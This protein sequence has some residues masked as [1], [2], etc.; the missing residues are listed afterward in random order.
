MSAATAHVP[1]QLRVHNVCVVRYRRRLD[2]DRI[3]E[4]AWYLNET[5]AGDV[6]VL[7]LLLGPTRNERQRVR[8][9]ALQKPADRSPTWHLSNE[10]VVD[11]DALEGPDNGPAAEVR[12]RSLAAFVALWGN[13]GDLAGASFLRG[14]R[15]RCGLDG[16]DE[17]RVSRLARFLRRNPQRAL[18]IFHSAFRGF[19]VVDTEK[20]LTEVWLP[21]DHGNFHR[22][23][24]R[25]AAYIL[26]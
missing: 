23:E 16:H 1:R 3:A 18:A 12:D 15:L 22:V 8:A 17:I 2:V 19:V 21:R 14:Q 10:P 24:G 20:M 9:W 13:S 26:Y 7:W 6:S 25:D 4:E 11:W 5:T